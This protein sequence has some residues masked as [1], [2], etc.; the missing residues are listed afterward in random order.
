MRR[1]K[2]NSLNVCIGSEDVEGYY[3]EETGEF[4]PHN[5]LPDSVGH[6][7]DM[8]EEMNAQSNSMNVNSFGNTE[9]LGSKYEDIDVDAY[10]S[11]RG[12]I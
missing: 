1:P 6:D 3:D 4:E 9:Y 8:V 12:E 5:D 7:A 11:T 2:F 10:L